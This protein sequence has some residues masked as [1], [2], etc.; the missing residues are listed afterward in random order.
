[1]NVRTMLATI[2]CI[3]L[4]SKITYLKC[5][6]ICSIC[7]QQSFAPIRGNSL[8]KTAIFSLQSLRFNFLATKLKKGTLPFQLYRKRRGM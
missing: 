5:A 4:Q 3:F 8:T 2:T 6:L 1:M 7:G